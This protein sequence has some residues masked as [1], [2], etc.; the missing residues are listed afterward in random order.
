[1]FFVKY[2]DGSLITNSQLYMII[3]QPVACQAFHN[4]DT[5]IHR[6][7]VYVKTV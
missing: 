7:L 6:I 5:D 4:F 1:V 3:V 2:C